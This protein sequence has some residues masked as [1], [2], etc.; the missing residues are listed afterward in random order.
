MFVWTSG[1]RNPLAHTHLLT[2]ANFHNYD[3]NFAL[4][5]HIREDLVELLI[6]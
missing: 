2:I 5:T 6:L 3:Y 1:F 4:I